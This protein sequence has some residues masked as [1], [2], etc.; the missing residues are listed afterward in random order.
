MACGNFAFGQ[1]DSAPRAVPMTSPTSIFGSGKLLES[2]PWENLTIKLVVPGTSGP[3]ARPSRLVA[4][5]ARYE[6]YT[7]KAPAGSGVISD[8]SVVALSNPYANAVCIARAEP[9]KYNCMFYVSSKTGVVAYEVGPGVIIWEN[10]Y[11]S[12]PNAQTDLNIAITQFEAAYD[13]KKF[14]ENFIAAAFKNTILIKTA[15]PA[16]YF[17]DGSSPG[18]GIVIPV[19][20][21]LDITDDTLHL[22]IHNP[23]TM[24]VASL[25]IDLK[26]KKVTK[27]IVDG[28]EM[29]IST[30]A[31]PFATPLSAK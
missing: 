3:A 31:L 7:V 10:N 23:K 1:S 25:W 27:S 9:P 8:F 12:I 22:V 29:V 24:K 4:V 2:S 18:G 19:V 14:S 5:P 11:L 26:T 16:Y 13:G 28:Q 15:T 6:R 30:G 17:S 20:D 21:A